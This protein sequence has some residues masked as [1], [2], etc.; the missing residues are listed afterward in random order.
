MD[1]ISQLNAIIY[2]TS[3]KVLQ[4]GSLTSFL[5][6]PVVAW[7]KRPEESGSSSSTT[8]LAASFH[9]SPSV[10]LASASSASQELARPQSRTAFT[11]N[12]RCCMS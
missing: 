9:I 5:H 8:I 2:P 12:S 10:G 7:F 6:P 3:W 1:T 11:F 4:H